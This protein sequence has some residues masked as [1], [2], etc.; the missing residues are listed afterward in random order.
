ME[1][2]SYAKY[3][4]NRPVCKEKPHDP[5]ERGA[6]LHIGLKLILA[7]GKYKQPG[8]ISALEYTSSLVTI[9]YYF[10]NRLWDLVKSEEVIVKK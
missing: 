3:I 2:T 4:R 1:I 5:M 6:N 7:P 10:Q 9:T 8:E